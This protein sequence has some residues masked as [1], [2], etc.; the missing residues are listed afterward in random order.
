[1]YMSKLEFLKLDP[2]V[3]GLGQ[4][5]KLKRETKKKIVLEN[6]GM[7]E[8]SR[9]FHLFYGQWDAPF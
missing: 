6:V 1:M 3:P 9:V 2:L 5:R 7:R 8:R 4:K